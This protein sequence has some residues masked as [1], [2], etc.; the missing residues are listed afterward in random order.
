M[1]DLST[2]QVQRLGERLRKSVTPEDLALLRELRESYRPVLDAVVADVRQVVADADVVVQVG[3]RPAKTTR[4][5][6][7][8]LHRE[9]TNLARMQD[10]AGCRFVVPRMV[11]Q[12]AV[13]IGL[14]GRH[15]DWRVD[16]LRVT[17]HH[18]YRAVHLITP[19]PRSVE[20]QVRTIVQDVWA[21]VSEALDR[22]YEGFKYGRGPGEW[23]Q[24]LR[25]GSARIAAWEAEGGPDD[26]LLLKPRAFAAR[27]TAMLLEP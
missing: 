12:N 7:A 27:L 3:T 21:S 14:A 11:D 23:V 20:V 25:E 5:I 1:P 22:Q 17:P 10:I 13:V 24:R 26:E 15:Q 16:D 8:K 2:S 18:G 9:R 6:I 19:R 4:S